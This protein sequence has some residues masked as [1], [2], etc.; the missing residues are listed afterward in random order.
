MLTEMRIYTCYAGRAAEF[1]EFYRRVGLAV[2]LPVGGRLKGFYRTDVG[3]P[4]RVILIWDYESYEDRAGRRAKL[5]ENR[6]WRAFLEQAGPM[7]ASEENM[8]LS[9]VPTPEV[10]LA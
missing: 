7:V 1:A 4:N 5:A 9:A 2:Q 6:D 3:D 10:K 8:I